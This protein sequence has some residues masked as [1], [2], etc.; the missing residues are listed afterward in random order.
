ML[1]H[2]AVDVDLR[3][4]DRGQDLRGH[5]QFV[6][7]VRFHRRHT[8]AGGRVHQGNSRRHLPKHV[9]GPFEFF[10]LIEIRGTDDRFGA[11]RLFDQVRH[12]RPRAFA[13]GHLQL[14][15][16]FREPTV[17]GQ[18]FQPVQ[19]LGHAFQHALEKIRAEI[20]IVHLEVDV[21][22]HHV[23]P[24]PTQKRRQRR[25]T[26]VG[27]GGI[28][29]RG[30]E[31]HDLFPGPAVTLRFRATLLQKLGADQPAFIIVDPHVR[32]SSG[33]H[34][35]RRKACPGKGRP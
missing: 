13:Q 18:S 27:L 12:T 31:Q 29:I 32:H 24:G 16:F 10:R 17:P 11:L 21:L 25:E 8:N 2:V 23:V 22:L 19:L 6:R 4:L 26:Q 5:E 15:F 14:G 1:E 33:R 28:P 9:H 35:D 7:Q 34:P 20:P 3:I 30:E